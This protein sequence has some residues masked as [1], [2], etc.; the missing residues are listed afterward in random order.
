[1]TSFMQAVEALEAKAKRDKEALMFADRLADEV[2]TVHGYNP[3]HQGPF[4]ACD[5]ELCWKA[6]VYRAKREE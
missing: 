2:E 1:M 6:R 3:E 4:E 5:A